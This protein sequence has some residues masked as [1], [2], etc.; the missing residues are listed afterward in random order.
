MKKRFKALTLFSL[1]GLFLVGLVFSVKGPS[2]EVKASE[3][4]HKRLYVVLNWEVGGNPNWNNGDMY[5][6]YWGEGFGTTWN[7]NEPKMTRILDDHHKGL[8][9]FDLPV[10][11]DFFILKNKRGDTDFWNRTGDI[12]VSQFFDPSGYRAAHITKVMD[13]DYRK[14]D[15]TTENVDVNKLAEI[16][17]YFESCSPSYTVG[18]NAWPQLRDVFVTPSGNFDNSV[19]L[20]EKISENTTTV[21]NKIAMLT[22][23][24]NSKGQS[25]EIKFYKDESNNLTATLIIGAIGITTLA[26]YYF[27]T[28][29]S[30][31]LA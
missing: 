29:K 14:V 2:I 3:Q 22:R 13:G 10:N 9:F 31:V 4:T 26:G 19:N 27:I 23:E 18:Y 5:I 12:S 24:Y 1:I 15:A 20:I 16:L 25:N 11:T 7:E 28:K 30:K 8:Y 6:H 21:G 17:S